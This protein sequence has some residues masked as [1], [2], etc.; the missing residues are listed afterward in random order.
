MKSNSKL[1]ILRAKYMG[2]CFGVSEA[3]DEVDRYV[4]MKKDQI[5]V[6]GMLVHNEF[7]IDR[8]KSRG[9]IFISEEDIL[10]GKS[11][12]KKGDTVI[13]RA[14]GTIK[15]I[16]DLL[17]DL[18]VNLIDMACVYVKR[19]R[20]QVSIW[21]DKGYKLIFIGDKD[22]VEVKGITSYSKNALIFSDLNELKTSN[23][24]VND[25]WIFLFQTTYNKFLFSEINDYINSLYIN[26][27][28]IKSICGATHQRQSSVEEL[29][30][31]VDVMIIIG[32]EQ[33]SNT[34]KLFLISQSINKRSYWIKRPEDLTKEMVENVN[35]IGISAGASTP[36]EIVRNVEEKI[37]E[38]S[39]IDDIK[40]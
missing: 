8:L 38:I 29:A 26:S 40:I 20:E 11:P 25:K 32:S 36:E 18:E 21:E 13:I 31:E 35:K 15:K 19:A 24:D 37:L 39:N 14:H 2:F 1:E 6:L 33:S 17:L 5:Y 27:K 3:I 9:V 16:Q 4:N 23:L 28:V 30:K 12:L 34:H 10:T 7:V 22:H